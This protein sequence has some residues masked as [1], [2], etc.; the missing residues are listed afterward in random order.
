MDYTKEPSTSMPS[1]P[2]DIGNFFLLRH[3]QSEANVKGLIASSP[4]A[5]ATAFGLTDKGRAQVHA[6]L[7]SALATNILPQTCHVISSP[8]RRARE[9][10][11]IAAEILGTVVRIDS[12]LAERGFGEFELLSDDHYERV[13]SEDRSDPTHEKWGVESA[14]AILS[15]V[16]TLIQELQQADGSGAY[17]LCTH[18][19]VASVLL[20]A[21]SGVALTRHRD[22]GAMANGEVRSL[23]GQRAPG[24][25]RL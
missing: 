5:A 4:A 12:R 19:D 10:A 14:S 22:V 23:A 6:S 18:G 21:A 20:C 8:L 13:W 25:S 3:G 7:T 11:E 17:V 2:A 15:R 24:L 9:S 16:S 1:L